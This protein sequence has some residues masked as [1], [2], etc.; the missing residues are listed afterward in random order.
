MLEGTCKWEF[1]GCMVTCACESAGAHCRWLFARD[2]EGLGLGQ[3]WEQAG[4]GV[5]PVGVGLG[6]VVGLEMAVRP[7]AC[8]W[9]WTQ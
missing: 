5:G 7:W 3:H 4:D 6:L 2:K 8:N 9:A 1:I